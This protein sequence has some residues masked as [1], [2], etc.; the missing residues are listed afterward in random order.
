MKRLADLEIARLQPIVAALR[1]EKAAL[2]QQLLTGKR[3][4]ITITKEAA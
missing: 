1:Q 4:V 3:R 2:M